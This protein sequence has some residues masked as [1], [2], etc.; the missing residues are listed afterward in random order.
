M[1][2]I[3]GISGRFSGRRVESAHPQ[4][5]VDQQFARGSINFPLNRIVAYL[6]ETLP[7]HCVLRASSV[8]RRWLD[9]LEQSRQLIRTREIHVRR[10]N[11]TH[12]VG[13]ILFQDTSSL[14]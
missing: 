8:R 3:R 9:N 6:D 7:C 4:E 1:I 2:F 5:T 14:R 10:N 13:I 11:S 12:L